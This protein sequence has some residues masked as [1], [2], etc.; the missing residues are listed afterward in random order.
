MDHTELLKEWAK[1][2]T[3]KELDEAGAPSWLIGWK[4]MQLMGPVPDDAYDHDIDIYNIR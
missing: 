3:M 2:K 4:N 1:D